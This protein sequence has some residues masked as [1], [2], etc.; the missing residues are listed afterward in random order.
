MKFRFIIIDVISGDIK[1]T[2]VKE[3]AVDCARSEDF[4]V[5]DT[6]E[7]VWILSDGDIVEIEEI[8]L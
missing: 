1:G 6:E 2:N 5:Y 7:G 4:F 8:R 3:R